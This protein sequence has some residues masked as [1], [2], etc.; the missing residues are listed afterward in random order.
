MFDQRSGKEG[1][2]EEEDGEMMNSPAAQSA[3]K[4]C[5]CLLIKLLTSLHRVQGCSLRRR[6]LRKS[7]GVIAARSHLRRDRTSNSQ[8]CIK[9]RSSGGRT[10]G[11]GEGMLVRNVPYGL[12]TQERR[13]RDQRK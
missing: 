1:K 8:A 10:D 6:G 4:V 7:F 11:E 9:G 2:C 3:I 5:A 13:K 12:S